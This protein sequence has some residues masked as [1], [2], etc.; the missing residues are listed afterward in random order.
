[1]YVHY[2]KDFEDHGRIIGVVVA[3]ATN[4]VG[5]VIAHP[6]SVNSKEAKEDILA[7]AIYRAMTKSAEESLNDLNLSF[8]PN[9]FTPSDRNYNYRRV[10]LYDAFRT[11]IHKAS[12]SKS[13]PTMV[14]PIKD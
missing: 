5:Y 13:L 14:D 6:G 4:K 12:V 7:F 9:V 11:M 8:K 3:V 2:V 1:M 10:M